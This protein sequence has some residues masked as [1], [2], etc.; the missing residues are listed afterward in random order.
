VADVGPT[1]TVYIA[2]M[3]CS[4][5]AGCPDTG[6][7][8]VLSSSAN[9]VDW[10]APRRIGTGPPSAGTY[11]TLPGLAADPGRPGSL[12]LAYYRLRGA[13]IDAFFISSRDE[14]ARWTAPRRLTPESILRAWLPNTQY[15]PML[16]DYISTSYVDGR[17]VPI[18]IMAGR[19]RGN[20]LDESVFAALVR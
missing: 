12:A 13:A 2:W 9:G 20:R 11:Y 15:G 18:L 1:G 6:A 14:G 4:F 10:T 19:P 3:D 8:L 16:A 5:R 7:D 17:P